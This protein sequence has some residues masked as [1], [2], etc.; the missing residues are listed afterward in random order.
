MPRFSRLTV[1]NTILEIAAVP[2]FTPRDVESAWR[3]I[4]ACREAG[5]PVV[6]LTFRAPDTLEILREVEARAAS[7]APDVILG[8]GTIYDAP[9]AALFVAAGASFVVSPVLNPDLARF[10]NRRKVAWIPG[11]GS[12]SE[13]SEAEELGA[14][15]VKLFP[16]GAFDGPAFIRALLN[17]SPWSRVMPTAVPPTEERITTYFRAGAAAVGVGPDLI[18]D[19]AQAEPDTSVLADRIRELLGWIRAARD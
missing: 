1:L 15:F 18:T 4:R 3:V 14:E 6:E 2:T 11:C 16:A 7:E 19:A 9:T 10:C 17:P 5:A 12:A 8:V 13:V